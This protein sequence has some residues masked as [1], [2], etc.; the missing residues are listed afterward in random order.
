MKKCNINFESKYIFVDGV[1]VHVDDYIREGYTSCGV[2][3]NG[4]ELILVNGKIRTPHFRHK[5]TEDVGGNPMTKWHCE[6]QGN[7]PHTEVHFNKKSESDE[8]IKN[9]RADVHISEHSI[10]LEFQ[11]S[12]MNSSE[13]N[14]R[15]HDYALHGQNIIWIVN[16]N[17][18]SYEEM[19]DNEGYLITF[20]KNIW[21]YKSFLEKH[22][23]IIID[24]DGKLFKVPV[25][26]VRANLIMVK[27]YRNKHDV[28]STLLNNPQ[29]VWNMWVDD[30]EI[31]VT[32]TNWQKGAG[33]GKT[34][35]IWKTISEKSDK[36]E[37]FILIKDHAGK[38]VIK[39]EFIEQLERDETHIID[40]ISE[41]IIT[42]YYRQI[43]IWLRR[44]ENNRQIRV[45]IGTVDSFIHAIH[46]P[47]IC[48]NMHSS[49]DY[50]SAQLKSINE[51]EQCNKVHKSTGSI[52]YAGM[53]IEIARKAEIWIDEAQDLEIDYYTAFVKLMLQT[54]IDI[55]IV[56][57]MLQS[58]VHEQNFL[59]EA[60][61]EGKKKG[62]SNI[63]II[64]KPFINENRRIKVSGMAD[65]IN[66]LIPFEKYGLPII[67]CPNIEAQV[68]DASLS[69][70]RIEVIDAT[71]LYASDEG[72]QKVSNYVDDL[73]K[74]VDLQVKMYNYQP[75]DFLF[76]FDIL[77][78]N[79]LVAELEVRLNDY[80][81]KD[82]RYSNSEEYTQYAVL[83]KHQDGQVI[84]TNISVHA[85]RIMSIRSSK[86]DG[87]SVVF[88]L[89]CTE[90]SLKIC[91][92][93]EVNIQWWSHLHVAFTR[94][95][96]KV[97]FALHKNNDRIHQLFGSQGYA[98][99][100][101]SIK[102]KI[103]FDKIYD[104][105]NDDKI[106]MFLKN[107][108]IEEFD[109][110]K[111]IVYQSQSLVDW[112]Y[113]CIRRQVYYAYILYTILKYTRNT[114]VTKPV[115]AILKQISKL[116]VV[117]YPPKKFYD[118]LREFGTPF[119]T[120]D[121][122]LCDMSHKPIYKTYRTKIQEIMEKIKHVYDDSPD[123]ICNLSPME[124]V[125]SNY[126]IELYKH[127][128]Y[129]TT[130]PCEIY[131]II[132]SFDENSDDKKIADLL[133]ESN[134]I[135]TVVENAMNDITRNNKC[136]SITWNIEEWLSH[137][138]KT[139]IQ[140]WDVFPIIGF[141]EH[142]VYN[143]MFQTDLSKMNYWSTMK[144]IALKMFFLSQVDKY[145]GKSIKI[146]LFLLKNN[147]HKVYEWDFLINSDDFRCI[148]KDAI[149][150][151][152]EKM[153]E[154]LF[155]YYNYIK[156]SP[157]EWRSEKHRT[158]LMFFYDK[159][160][161]TPH[162]AKF[163]NSLQRKFKENGAGAIFVKEMTSDKTRFVEELNFV[164]NE[165]L[166]TTVCLN[167]DYD[168]VEW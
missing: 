74:L 85:T 52:R 97:Y 139:E 162:I 11:H 36:D 142:E 143:L 3:E 159:Y 16:G 19:K 152:L 112:N 5:H 15:N 66:K 124:M 151:Y 18:I 168:D 31:K 9:R 163:F 126:M 140:I 63:K 14:D 4:H 81:H 7:F 71:I 70:R 129:H 26:E 135:K 110:D 103:R 161:E 72:K 21:T 109:I 68:G 118:Y 10:V 144:K 50:C 20:S 147:T 130:T 105:V 55:V 57:D 153:H 145:R 76:L 120:P 122:P 35:S 17:G 157:K 166:D 42:A 133:K 138:D 93:R 108:G 39:Q 106:I 164:A 141:N 107:N 28:I 119:G 67:T 115:Y 56:G 60:I 155:N 8:Q 6:W 101:P 125:I 1:C 90:A 91:S 78:G 22:E 150:N 65:E 45:I 41:S 134:T 40:N 54:K 123:E 84:D 73:I 146:Y 34:Y 92:N 48:S 160:K 29:D 82:K 131:N 88:I 24:F 158:P 121:I 51:S 46:H 2:C 87:R 69:E 27:E 61:Q 117:C 98:L 13:V 94:S 116:D 154:E 96:H 149:L 12:N 165:L 49:S 100:V 59:T 25:R 102:N 148:Y 132:H 23:F 104:N 32:L 79:V 64:N 33:N 127:H 30:N 38:I 62:T 44:K 137:G 83:H 53:Q 136:K 58:L 80:W 77:K 113:H 167:V 128:K 43:I 47:D 89:K 114:S 75:N 156:N 86:G 99:Y 95:I 111:E 37:Y